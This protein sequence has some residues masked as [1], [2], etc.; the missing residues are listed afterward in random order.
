MWLLSESHCA[1]LSS[2][3]HMWALVVGSWHQPTIHSHQPL[4]LNIEQHLLGEGVTFT[5]LPQST[6]RPEE[7]GGPQP[8][9]SQRVGHNWSD[10]ALTTKVALSCLSASVLILCHLELWA[11]VLTVFT[12][13]ETWTWGLNWSYAFYM[14]SS[15]MSNSLQPHEV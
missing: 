14:V 10:S 8:M 7:P 6:L 11:V 15:V 2:R 13:T 5:N 9:G 12:K 1:H 3:S 4:R